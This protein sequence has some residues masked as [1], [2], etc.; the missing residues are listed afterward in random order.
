VRREHE[1]EE[2]TRIDGDRGREG[3]EIGNFQMNALSAA[4]A[5][6]ETMGAGC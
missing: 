2:E 5:V 1:G 6:T 4:V 3:E